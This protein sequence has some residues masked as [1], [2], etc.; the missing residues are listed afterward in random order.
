MHIFVLCCVYGLK[1]NWVHRTVGALWSNDTDE[2]QDMQS[3][4]S[5]RLNKSNRG[6]SSGRTDARPLSSITDIIYIYT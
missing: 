6:G 4:Q 5:G 2:A 1:Y 3:N